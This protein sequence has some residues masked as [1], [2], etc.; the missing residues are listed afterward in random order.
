M[1][2]L[3]LFVLL[4]LI[5][6]ISHGCENNPTKPEDNTPNPDNDYDSTVTAYKPNIYIYPNETLS[7]SVEVS[8][9]NGG[10][11]IESIPNYKNSWEIT[12]APDG[13]IND[14]YEYLFYE[15]K[16][17]DLAQKEFGW[18]IAKSNLK[19][20]FSENMTACGFSQKE[21]SD[22]IEYWI[23]I[24]TEYKYYEIYPQYKSTLDEMVKI[25]YSIEPNNFYRLF[26]FLK[27]RDNNQ[28]Q[29]LTPSIETAKRENYF[30]VEWGVIL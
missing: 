6:F 14:T 27:G 16:I 26:Y 13:K 4:F 2:K 7:L 10:E 1:K 18:V 30:A 19:D 8:F 20:F 28:I 24:L 25:S 15:C 21:I 17:P 9:P 12:V 22:F 11:V 5:L 29:L 3:L 23:P